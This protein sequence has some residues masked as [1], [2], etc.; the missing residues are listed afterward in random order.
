[1]G[2]RFELSVVSED[3]QWA[4]RMLNTARCAFTAGYALVVSISSL[5]HV[6]CFSF[7]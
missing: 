3:G 7:L 4:N 6:I 5:F 2:N 1:M